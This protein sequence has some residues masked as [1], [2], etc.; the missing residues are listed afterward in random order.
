MHLIFNHVTKLQH[1][2]HT[3]SS[4]LVE[5]FTC[6][7]I[8]QCGL[9]VARQTG[10]VCPFVQIVQGRTIKNRSGK[11]NAQFATGTS[12]NCF[13][14]LTDVHTWRHTQGIQHNIDRRSISQEWHI[15]LTDDARHDT[16]VTVTSGHLVTD[17]NLTFFSH[18]DL[19]HLNNAGG[20]FVTDGD[21]KLLTFQFSIEFFIFFQ[22]VDDQITNHAALVLISNPLAK[23]YGRVI[24]CFQITTGKLRTLGYDLSSHVVLH[25]LRNQVFSQCQQFINQD[26]LQICNFC[27]KLFINLWQKSFVRH[28]RATCLYRTGEQTLVNDNTFQRRWSLQWSIFHITS[29]I[30]KNRTKQLLFRRRIG[31]AFRSN[32][33]NQNISRLN[34]SSN[35]YD[36]IFIQVF[37]RIFTDVGDVRSKLFHASLGLADFQREFFHMHRSQDVFTNNTFVQHDGILIVVSFPRNI[38]NQQVFT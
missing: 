14:H 34:A 1:V 5:C 25:T 35:A 21:G 6:T 37:G 20:K 4:L 24:Q 27:F 8:I 10:L 17:T 29:L 31:L 32:L 15:F 13:K 28:L 2:G 36:T 16:F 9:S 38:G 12:Q 11:L 22:E 23:L 3:D 30:S 7:A 19:R 33:A 18:I 26:L